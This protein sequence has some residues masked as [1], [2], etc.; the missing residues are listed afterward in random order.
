MSRNTNIPKQAH[1]LISRYKTSDPFQLAE[2]LGINMMWAD[3]LKKLKGMF[4]QIEGNGYIIINSKLDKDKAKIVCAHELGHFVLHGSSSENLSM[5]EYELYDMS[6]VY[7]YEA[8][9]FAA[10]LLLDDDEVLQYIFEYGYNAQQIAAIM[11]SDIN[12]VAL[13]IADM[14]TR[15]YKFNRLDYRSDFLKS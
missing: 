2:N 12:L 6:S 13:K 9:I 1:S 4:L 15:G 14:N 5:Q 8:N 11:H 7:E 3:D 10:S